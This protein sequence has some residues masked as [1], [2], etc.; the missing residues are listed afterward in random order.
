MHRK[1]RS[2]S[3]SPTA[4]AQPP[5]PA[6][7]RTPSTSRG[8]GGFVVHPN[9][10]AVHSWTGIALHYHLATGWNE[11]AEW[12]DPE[13]SSTLRT[14]QAARDRCATRSLRAFA[15]A[16]ASLADDVVA[17]GGDLIIRLE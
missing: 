16:F 2:R 5:R 7:F 15:D 13:P 10:T 17:R 9:G 8:G 14:L 12:R 11:E 3:P 6:P 1:P 4:P